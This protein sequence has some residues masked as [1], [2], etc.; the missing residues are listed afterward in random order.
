MAT[1]DFLLDDDDELLMRTGDFV[2]GDASKQH[3]KCLVRAVPGQYRQ[4]PM[5]GADVFSQLNG[6][7]PD[8]WVRNLRLQLEADGMAVEEVSYRTNKL[9]INGRY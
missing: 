6:P 9:T 5:V 8:V 7:N 1:G 4:W 3:A 2:I